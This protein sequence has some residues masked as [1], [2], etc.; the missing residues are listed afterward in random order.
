MA[1]VQL[2]VIEMP[3]GLFDERSFRRAIRNIRAA[4]AKDIKIDFDVTT[5]TWTNPPKA[6]IQL[7]GDT[8]ALIFISNDRYT[9]VNEG[10]KAHQI[11]PRNASRLVFQANYK[12]KTV[13]GT[14]ASRPGGSFG[15]TVY[16]MGVEHPGT[17]ARKFDDLIAAKWNK[18]LP[19][20]IDRMILA[21]LG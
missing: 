21:E 8:T 3:G 16:S 10:T 1:K 5:R 19:G 11:L 13:V 17:Q 15:P 14:I 12:A 2:E 7:V 4:R 6:K 18:L 20:I 9:W